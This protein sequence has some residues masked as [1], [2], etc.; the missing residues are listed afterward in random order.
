MTTTVSI[1]IQPCVG[2]AVKV[3]KSNGSSDL[4][5]AERPTL[6][7]TLYDGESIASITEVEAPKTE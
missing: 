2:K 6:N 5:T 4:L 1:T 7:Y 3:E